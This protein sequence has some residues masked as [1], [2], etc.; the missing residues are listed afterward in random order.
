MTLRR[1]VITGL[2]VAAAAIVAAS[3]MAAPDQRAPRIVAAVMQDSDGDGRADRVR[4]TYSE[5]VRHRADRDGRYPFR[6][7]G[8][9]VRSVGGARGKTVTVVLVEKKVGDAEVRPSVRYRRTGSEP[10]ADRAGNQARGQV[11]ARTRAHGRGPSNP[12]PVT[13]DPTLPL[14]PTAAD[15]D[16]DGTANEQDC[17]PD[18]PTRHPKA[19]DRP[20]LAFVDANCDGIDG[21][22]AKAIFVSP[23]GKDTNP[24]TKTAPKRQ[25]QA[26]VVAAAAGKDEYVLAAAG[27]YERVKARSGVGIYG[28]YSSADWSRDAT[29]VTSIVGTPEG[30]YAEKA[31]GVVLQLLTVRGEGGRTAP[32]GMTYYGI[33][34]ID[35]SSLTLQRVSVSAAHGEPGVDGSNGADGIRGAHGSAGR[36]GQCGGGTPGAGGGGGAV[37]G[38]TAGGAGGR[39]GYEDDSELGGGGASIGE[40]GRAGAGGALGGAGGAGGAPGDPGYSGRDGSAG[41]RGAD[42]DNGAGGSGTLEYAAELWDGQGGGDGKDAGRGYGGGGGGGSG[43]QHCILCNDGS[44]NGGGGGGSGGGGGHGG[45]RGGPGGGS[46]GLYLFQSTVTVSEASSVT[47]GNGGPG[48]RGGDGGLQGAGGDPGEGATYCSSEIGVG[49]N[50]GSGGAGGHGGGGGGGAGGPSIAIFKLAAAKATVSDDST[51]RYGT[52]G[53][54]GQGG[55]GAGGTRN[56]GEAGVV[57]L[58]Y[59]LE[60]DS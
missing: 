26:A 45:R 56:P 4:V 11:F 3:P 18:D 32:A 41:A 53:A 13:P 10:V 35:G 15:R 28:G 2:A 55:L 42:G 20:D 22:E 33:R 54:G 38:G 50:G 5:R 47:A 29:L 37:Q 40:D 8:Y 59:G 39:G 36:D 27:A 6:V 21:T 25:I 24:G 43:A 12:T 57:H 23:Q 14:N 30:I 60:E 52:A 16:G 9:R 17:A 48:G 1:S 58:N 7:A 46:F 31:T 51:L 44:G 49:G 19:V 34:A